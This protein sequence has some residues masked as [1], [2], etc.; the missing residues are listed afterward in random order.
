M[1][2]DPKEKWENRR[3]NWKSRAHLQEK[4]EEN[5]RQFAASQAVEPASQPDLYLWVETIKLPETETK[6]QADEPP[7][8]RNGDIGIGVVV[9]GK[10]IFIELHW[11][12]ME[13]AIMPTKLNARD[14]REM[15][16]KALSTLGRIE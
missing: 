4:R 9:G 8:K 11:R 6:P 12:G 10:L 16:K 1:A 15:F 14:L 2:L 7:K 5:V 13:G 3:K